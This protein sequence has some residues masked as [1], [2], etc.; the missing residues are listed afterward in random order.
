VGMSRDITDRRR[1]EEAA[2]FL[3]EAS[4]A[5]STSL[6]LDTTLESLAWIAVPGLADLCMVYLAQED[7]TFERTA[8]AHEDPEVVRMVW[9]LK[10]GEC[11]DPRRKFP[12]QY[13]KNSG[14][15]VFSDEKL[16]TVLRNSDPKSEEIMQQLAPR[17][18]MA[19]PLKSRDRI[20]GMITFSILEGSRRYQQDDLILAEE[21]A[22][23]TAVAIENARLYR[24]AQ[25]ERRRAE[26]SR[27]R[28]ATQY[29]VMT[30]LAESTEW[31][32]SASD[33][34]ETIA[35]GLGWDQGILWQERE[36]SVWI[37]KDFGPRQTGGPAESERKLTELCISDRERLLKRVKLSGEPV[38]S[39]AKSLDGYATRVLFPLACGRLLHGVMEF[40]SRSEMNCDD[41]LLKTL[42]TIGAQVSQ[43]VERTRAERALRE[44]EGRFR[45][46]AERAGLETAGV[47]TAAAQ[48]D[49]VVV[50]PISFTVSRGAVRSSSLTSKELQIV[51]MLHQ[52]PDHRLSRGELVHGIWGKLKVSTNSLDVHLFNVRKK[53]APLGME[54]LFSP[55]NQ[56]SLN[57]ASR[58]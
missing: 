21:L 33:I 16:E 55:P 49:D 41:E 6:D 57:L 4:Q 13:F 52:A 40:L 29:S 32:K 17:S 37:P 50:D 39:S 54:I 12:M 51:A 1:N 19:V 38:F 23:R 7:G 10:M 14:A 26:A 36:E 3:A 45:K 24:Q 25:E 43:F 22:R 58:I 35:T 31:E 47:P 53:L 46:L 8:V 9:Q 27:R 2:H 48:N 20:L 56:Y 11:S 18:T 42:S 15:V 5:L 28:V 30:L 34:L 44:N